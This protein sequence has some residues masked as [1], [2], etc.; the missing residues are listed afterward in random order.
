MTQESNDLAFFANVI[1]T[2]NSLLIHLESSQSTIRRTTYDTTLSAS[3]VKIDYLTEG[4]ANVLFTIAPCKS[5]IHTAETPNTIDL[6]GY[7]L[8]LRKADDNSKEN[9]APPFVQS[10][11]IFRFM[12]EEIATVIP[13]RFLLEHLVVECSLPV[14]KS[15]NEILKHKEQDQTR[16]TKRCGLFLPENG[17]QTGLLVEYLRASPEKGDVLLEFKPKWLKQ[18]PKA[19]E[20]SRRC[21]TCAWQAFN[22]VDPSKRYCPLA[23]S[24]SDGTSKAFQVDRMLRQVPDYERL[25]DKKGIKDAIVTYLS[26]DGASLLQLLGRLQ[27]QLDPRGILHWVPLQTENSL[28][29]EDTVQK[30]IISHTEDLEKLSKAMTLRDCTL[31]VRLVRSKDSTYLVTGSLGDLDPKTPTREKVLKWAKDDYA[32]LTGGFYAGTNSPANDAEQIEICF[33]QQKL[34]NSLESS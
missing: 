10:V 30:S 15:C 21:R 1:S 12:G 20:S 28:Q 9:K 31:F 14:I 25:E 27:S 23:L 6:G 24:Q 32:L 5:S 11:E 22:G 34:A 3:R 8:R 16:N 18:S 33:L 2:K 26:Q 19:P 7:L 13:N 4:A 17:D 29:V